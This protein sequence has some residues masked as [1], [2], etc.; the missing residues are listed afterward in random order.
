MDLPGYGLLL[1]GLTDQ[2]LN[3]AV[4]SWW[5][6]DDRLYRGIALGAALLPSVGPSIVKTCGVGQENEA[7]CCKMW[8][9]FFFSLMGLGSW[10]LRLDYTWIGKDDGH[11][12]IQETNLRDGIQSLFFCDLVFNGYAAF[13]VQ[14][15]FIAYDAFDPS[16]RFGI[17]LTSCCFS[18]FY[19]MIETGRLIDFY[20]EGKDM[21]SPRIADKDEV[22]VL[23]V[24]FSPAMFFLIADVIFRIVTF[25]CLWR[26][27]VLESWI[28]LGALVFVHFV[29]E[30]LNISHEESAAEA[31]PR[32]EFA[33]PIELTT[34]NN[35]S[36][37]G[38]RSRE[39]DDQTLTNQI[40]TCYDIR[41]VTVTKTKETSHVVHES[42][43]KKPSKKEV[44]AVSH[45]L[46]DKLAK[47]FSDDLEEKKNPEK[48]SAESSR[49]FEKSL[50]KMLSIKGGKVT[51]KT[52]LLCR[53][54]CLWTLL[55]KTLVAFLSSTEAYISW[56]AHGF[57]RLNIFKT[58]GIILRWLMNVFI[59]V[60]FTF[61]V[62]G[63]REASFVWFI[64]GSVAGAATVLFWS[65]EICEAR[66]HQ[67][68]MD[69]DAETEV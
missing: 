62:P 1:F 65:L 43:K 22:Q 67:K 26:T 56:Q 29:V 12:S 19:A 31:E 18:L 10:I 60:W 64:V 7:S 37:A 66:A 30:A 23:C 11:T 34:H 54:L 24:T 17:D 50:L 4:I 38:D 63:G 52:C 53:D 51:R 59:L 3:F 48:M 57:T 68:S 55:C 36:I 20:N 9:F 49:K 40:P 5:I 14:L 58:I 69:S 6:W 28:S 33:E 13:A 16:V 8:R 25:A 32:L 46:L 27:I 21:A 35:F 39:S 2:L 45:A 15:F 42:P 47:L 41:P 44:V 61:I